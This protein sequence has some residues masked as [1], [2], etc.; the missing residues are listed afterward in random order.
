MDEAEKVF[1]VVFPSGGDSAQVGHPG[2]PAFRFH[3][4]AIVVHHRALFA[5]QLATSAM[6]RSLNL[7]ELLQ[8]EP[9]LRLK[10]FR[11]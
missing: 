4:G 11:G 9:P 3:C 8:N 5:D 6:L 1:D 10:G 2:E 7:T